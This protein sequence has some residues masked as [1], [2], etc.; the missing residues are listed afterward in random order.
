MPLVRTPDTTFATVKDE[1]ITL[2]EAPQAALL[3]W[4]PFLYHLVSA[5]LKGAIA[6][7]TVITVY[8][9]ALNAEEGLGEG[10][11]L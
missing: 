7:L 5:C 8:A 4:V 9:P 6:N 10:F 11:I 1:A 3:A 2:N